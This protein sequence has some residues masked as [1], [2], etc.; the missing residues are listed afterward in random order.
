MNILLY[1]LLLIIG[2]LA[3]ASDKKPEQ[4]R[5]IRSFPLASMYY[6]DLYKKSLKTRETLL[7][8]SHKVA[9]QIPGAEVVVPGLKSFDRTKDKVDLDYQGDWKKLTDLVRGSISFQ[10]MDDLVKGVFLF[11][12]FLPLEAVKDRIYSPTPSG[13]RDILALFRDPENGIV[14]EIQFHLCHILRAK[15]EAH[16]LYERVQAIQRRAQRQDRLLN[17]R[18][19]IKIRQLEQEAKDVYA[20]A[21]ERL[22]K[23]IPCS[24]KA[25]L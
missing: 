7:E 25:K 14:G 20:R 10:T 17:D 15:E 24:I 4:L 18:E 1:F 3:Q 5:D 16:V 19:E 21:M 23:K 8:V 13:Y 11:K 2:F 22:D 6:S 9:L 12:N